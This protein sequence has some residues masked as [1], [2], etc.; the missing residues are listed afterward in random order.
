MFSTVLV[1]VLQYLGVGYYNIRTMVRYI[2]VITNSREVGAHDVN[3]P[4][5]TIRG[6]YKQDWS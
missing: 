1:Y 6:G 3:L 2:A 5:T 4:F